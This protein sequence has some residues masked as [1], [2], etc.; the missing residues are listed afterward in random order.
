WRNSTGVGRRRRAQF[1]GTPEYA[2]RVWLDLDR[3]RAYN[4]NSD[5]IM[6]AVSEQSMIG[7]PGRLG[8]ASGRTSQT[9]E[10]VLTWPGRYNK[11]EQ[12]ADIILKATPNGEDLL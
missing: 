11:P 3:M 7:S 2:M 8:Q 5:D 12:Y 6:K 9:V 4:V 1:L 10:Y